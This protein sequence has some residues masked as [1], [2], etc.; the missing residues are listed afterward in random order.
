MSVDTRVHRGYGTN[1]TIDF[2]VHFGYSAG[3]AALP[4]DLFEAIQTKLTATSAL[5]TGFSHTSINPRFHKDR[6]HRRGDEGPVYPYCV[7]ANISARFEHWNNKST[8]HER[9]W[10]DFK[11]YSDDDWEADQ[12]LDLIVTTFSKNH[13]DFDT[14]RGDCKLVLPGSARQF[15]S[16]QSGPGKLAVYIHLVTIQFILARKLP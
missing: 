13:S 6:D 8:F 12:M 15:V 9:R 2:R 3:A 11:V 7:Y 16:E 10:I 5:T 4:L 14:Q 1:S